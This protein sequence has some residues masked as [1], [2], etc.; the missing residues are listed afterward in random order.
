MR[1]TVLY[2][3]ATLAVTIGV[4]HAAL[5]VGANERAAFAFA[6]FTFAVF[7]AFVAAAN[8]PSSVRPR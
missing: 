6:A 5:S 7:T 3:I 4:Y 2:A 8:G 1:R